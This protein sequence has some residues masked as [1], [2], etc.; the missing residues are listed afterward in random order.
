MENKSEPNK[1]KEDLA[2]NRSKREETETNPDNLLQTEGN[3]AK[4]LPS[5]KL[6]R[7]LD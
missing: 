4:S 5:P 1:A 3:A 7:I 6:P 2:Q